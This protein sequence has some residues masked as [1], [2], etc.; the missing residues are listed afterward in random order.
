MAAN[1]P[2]TRAKTHPVANA[3]LAYQHYERVFSPP[4]WHALRQAGAHP[5]RPLWASTS[6]KDPAYPDTRYVTEL[7]AP[8]VVNTMPEA[9][10]R[11][12]ADHGRV[13]TD[14]VRAH[15]DD[16]QQ[17]LDRLRAAD[18]DCDELFARPRPSPRTRPGPSRPPAPI[19]A[20]S[21]A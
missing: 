3:R 10:L 11:A 19:R 4:R 20:R 13:P 12:V 14:S 15:Y 18:V 2:W 6:V 16:A 17:V 7:V 9:T 5:Q 1:R 8:G 21:P